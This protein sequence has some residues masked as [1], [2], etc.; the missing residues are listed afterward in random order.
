MCVCGCGCVLGPPAAPQGSQCTTCAPIEL[1]CAAQ[2]INSQPSQKIFYAPPCTPLFSPLSPTDTLRLC[3]DLLCN[4]HS[5]FTPHLPPFFHQSLPP[6]I[7]PTRCP[8]PTLNKQHFMWRGKKRRLPSLFSL[9]VC[10]SVPL[11]VWTLVCR[12]M[13]SPQTAQDHIWVLN[14]WLVLTMRGLES[15]SFIVIYHQTAFMLFVQIHTHWLTLSHSHL[16]T[17]AQRTHTFTQ[18][19]CWSTSLCKAAE[20]SASHRVHTV[21]KTPRGW[22]TITHHDRKIYKVLCSKWT[23]NNNRRDMAPKLCCWQNKCKSYTP[24]L[25]QVKVYFLLMWRKQTALPRIYW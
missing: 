10:W 6:S 7:R 16:Y 21:D 13:Y 2:V 22:N 15:F 23:N 18:S 25:S 9:F 5:S 1:A 14:K 24:F 19:H 11:F 20:R 8:A 4:N 17:S 3:I 12:L